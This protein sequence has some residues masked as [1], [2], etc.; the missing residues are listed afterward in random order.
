MPDYLNIQNEM[1]KFNTQIMGQSMNINGITK[2]E[3]K[4]HARAQPTYFMD[5]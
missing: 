3:L 4:V 1:N 2:K 5:A